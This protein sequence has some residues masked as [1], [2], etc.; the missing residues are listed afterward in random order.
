MAITSQATIYTAAD[1]HRD[2]AARHPRQRHRVP[3]RRR[4]AAA[5]HR[6]RAGRLAAARDHADRRLSLPARRARTRSAASLLR[7]RASTPLDRPAAAV[8]AARAWIAAG[9]FAM[10]KVSAAQTGLRG[11]IVASEQTDEFRADAAWPLAARA[12]GRAPDLRRGRASARRS[13]ACSRSTPRSQ[14]AG[15]RRRAARPAYA[16]A[17]VM[18]RDTPRGLPL[19][20]AR[21]PSD[22]DA[23][24]DGRRVAGPRL[25]GPSRARPHARR[26]A[27]S[28][29]R[30]SAAAAV[31]RPELRRLQPVRHRHAVERVLRRHLRA[32]G[33]LGAVARRH[34]LAAGG[35]RV[36]H[37]VVVQR[38]R[39][40][41]RPRALRVRTSRSGPPTRRSGCCGR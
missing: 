40:R 34:A 30:T 15:L 9:Q 7:R 24:G 31:R 14:P 37:R 3:R 23:A 2:R 32:A 1:A 39:V 11:P 41:G 33:V 13:I 8:L 22:D 19:P 27:S 26:S 21:A 28:S 12:L 38:S 25:A 20:E 6:A 5:A 18:L 17:A 10:V 16:S 36:R 35:P 4:A 29:I